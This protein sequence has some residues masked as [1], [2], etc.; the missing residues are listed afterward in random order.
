M[1]AKPAASVATLSFKWPDI[2]S[3]F[4]KVHPHEGSSEISLGD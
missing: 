1:P 2:P 4:P 3:R